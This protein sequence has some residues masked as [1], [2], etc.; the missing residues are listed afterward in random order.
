[1]KAPSRRELSKVAKLLQE[2]QLRGLI[3]TQLPLKYFTGFVKAVATQ[4]SVVY[5][6]LSG[7][8]R[9]DSPKREPDWM[10]VGFPPNDPKY[11][12]ELLRCM[13]H[14]FPVNA[15]VSGSRT[16]RAFDNRPVLH[17]EWLTSLN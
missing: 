16:E 7:N 9:G 14:R 2:S 1:M 3:N 10:I 4:T 11:L 6:E 15:A 13:N 8:Y 17:I 12:S 5:V